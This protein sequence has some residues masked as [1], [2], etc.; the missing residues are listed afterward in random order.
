MNTPFDFYLIKKEVQYGEQ[1]DPSDLAEQF[2]PYYATDE[3]IKVQFSTGEIKSGTVGV[4]TGHKPV[5]LLMLRKNS[6]GSSWTLS[7]KD[8]ILK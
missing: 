2:K 4:T 6:T 7:D 3:R 5:F 8:I 1:F